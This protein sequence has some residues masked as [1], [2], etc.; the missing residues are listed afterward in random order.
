MFAF[1]EFSNQQKSQLRGGTG[2]TVQLALDANKTVYVYDTN[3]NA[4]YQPFHY[5]WNEKGEW[6][7]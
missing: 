2:W 7:K 4:W 6:V 3:S 5:R 1:G